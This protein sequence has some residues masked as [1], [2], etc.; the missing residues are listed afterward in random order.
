MKQFNR[1]L[2]VVAVVIAFFLL[3]WILV[4]CVVGALDAFVEWT[5]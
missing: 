3:A 5:L 4:I 1:S 2:L